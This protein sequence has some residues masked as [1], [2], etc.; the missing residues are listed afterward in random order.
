MNFTRRELFN[1]LTALGSIAVL[2][3]VQATAANT[4][5]P[6]AT[7]FIAAL[8]EPRAK[9]GTGAENWG[10]WSVDPGPRGVHLTRYSE[11]LADGSVA[12]A[13]WKFD[14]SDW[15]LD[16]NGLIMEHPKYGMPPGRY[17]VTGD[18]E[19]TTILTVHPKDAN[20]TQRWELANDATLYDVTHLRCRS[21]RYKPIVGS[22]ACSPASAPKDQ[23]RVAPGAAM[24]P[25]NGCEKQD[26]TVMF[27]IG[28]ED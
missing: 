14:S 9:S 18:R 15:W 26:Y 8:G 25:V 6:I 28:I 7:Q 2:G 1:R 16:E 5:K 12:K 3:N 11:L 22:S 20:S 17:M 4:F 24:P 13:G 10:L 21:A 23:F 19:I 27:I